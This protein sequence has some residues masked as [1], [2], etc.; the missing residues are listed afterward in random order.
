MNFLL[1][2]ILIILFFI[3]FVPLGMLYQLKNHLKN[4]LIY[5]KSYRIF[6]K[7]SWDKENAN[8]L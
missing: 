1:N 5:K 4:K 7:N 6:K 8:T 3:F 2:I